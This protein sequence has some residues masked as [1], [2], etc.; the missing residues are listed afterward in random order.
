MAESPGNILD[1]IPSYFEW[2]LNN[3]VTDG[4]KGKCWAMIYSP[5][6]NLELCT[7]AMMRKHPGVYKELYNSTPPGG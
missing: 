1:D 6:K 3:I 2:K 5:S 4:E 7:T